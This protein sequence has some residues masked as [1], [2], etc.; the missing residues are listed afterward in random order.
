MFENSGLTC[1]TLKVGSYLAHHLPQIHTQFIQRRPAKIPV[2][3]V[4][5]VYRQIRHER[6]SVGHGGDPPSLRRLRHVERL[7]RLAVLITQKWKLGA[8]PGTKSV[9]DLRG[10]NADDH[11]LAIIDGQFPLKFDKVAQ[12]HLAFTSPVAAVKGNDQR[13]FAGELRN[14][15]K[16]TVMIGEIKVGKPLSDGLI[17][18]LLTSRN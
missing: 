10:I 2:A 13:K 1:G 15:G 16:L 6:K 8:Q 12:L 5:I 3:T 4:Q 18:V 7:D 17:H 9:I 11:E 14:L